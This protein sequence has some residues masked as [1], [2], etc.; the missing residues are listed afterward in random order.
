MTRVVAN[1]TQQRITLSEGQSVRVSA[2]GPQGAA[3]SAVA[4]VLWGNVLGTLS[5][6]TDLQ[7]IITALQAAD[8]TLTSS[9]AAR[10]LQVESW[11]GTS[12]GSA[13]AQ[14]ITVSPAP[15]AYVAG[16]IFTF[17][18]G[19]TNTASATLNPNSLGAITLYDS[20]TGLVLNG[21]EII[22]GGLYTVLYFN[23]K[24]Y[25][26]NGNPSVGTYSPTFTGFSADPAS[27]VLRYTKIGQKVDLTFRMPNQGTS[28]A[29]GFTMTL[30][31]TAATIANM[32]WEVKCGSAFSSGAYAADVEAFINSAGT[33]LIF[34]KGGSTTGF[35]ND[36]LG[37]SANGQISYLSST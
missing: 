1:I 16:Q 15:A 10:T 5:D 24:L 19:F 9:I 31:F 25:L 11:G 34:A 4:S 14:T 3:G 28:N 7:T 32:A 23:S 13:N 8:T 30:P 37:K 26:L 36:G 22:A 18:A 20:R 12:G 6:Q 33:T 35:V 21:N 2:P 29:T 27:P 17:L